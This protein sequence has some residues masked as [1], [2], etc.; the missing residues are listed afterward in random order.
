M[1]FNPPN[2][3]KNSRN[4]VTVDDLLKRYR[5]LL[6]TAK[7]ELPEEKYAAFKLQL[8]NDTGISGQGAPKLEK[9]VENKN[10]QA[11]DNKTKPFK[12]KT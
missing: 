11:P 9:K 1:V 10:K 6:A 3:H 8:D 5:L 7:A 12:P 2:V 4:R